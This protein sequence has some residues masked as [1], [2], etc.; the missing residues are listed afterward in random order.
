M[1]LEHRSASESSSR[2][3]PYLC[4]LNSKCLLSGSSNIFFLSLVLSNLLMTYLG[5]VSFIFPILGVHWVSWNQ[6]FAKAKFGKI[7]AITSSTPF[8]PSLQLSLLL[9]GLRIRLVRLPG[10]A[11]GLPDALLRFCL[12]PFV[13]F[14]LDIYPARSSLLLQHPISNGPTVSDTSCSWERLRI[15][16]PSRTSS[17]YNSS[18]LTLSPFTFCYLSSKK[19]GGTLNT[20]LSN[21]SKSCTADHKVH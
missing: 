5:I 12:S 19:P 16:W 1:W 13:C 9:Q 20:L 3:H 14:I 21:L 18:A 4:S 17:S 15:L 11:P 6:G 10:A 7:S 8:F 2:C